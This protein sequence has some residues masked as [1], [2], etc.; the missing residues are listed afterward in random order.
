MQYDFLEQFS[1]RIKNIAKYAVL[2]SN[3]SQKAIWKNYGFAE[4]Y[5]Q[6]TVL[7]AVMLF[8]MEK[9]LRDDDCTMDDIS[10]FLDELNT[11]Y[12]HRDMS[13]EDC[14]ILSDFLINTVLS[15]DGIPM[16]YQAYSFE[17][18]KCE[19]V[20][21]SYL[22]NKIVYDEHNV[23]RTSYK[24]TDMGYDFILGTLEIEDNL[25]LS[26]QE[27]VFKLHLDKQNYDKALDDIKQMFARMRGQVERIQDA[28]YRIR[29]NPLNYNVEEYGNV[30]QG[31]LDT[32][33][34]I[35]HKLQ[36]YREK[37]QEI[38]VEIEGADIV[39]GTSDKYKLGNLREINA[40]LTMSLA[41]Y[42]KIMNNHF[43][44]K[45][46][47]AE[48]L[49]NIASL[50]MVQRYSLR[51][52]IFDPIMQDIRALDKIDYLLRPL[53]N[54]PLPKYFNIE[55]MLA[56]QRRCGR[57]EDDMQSELEDFDQEAWDRKQEQIRQE[58]NN[59]Y[60]ASLACILKA[61]YPTGHIT[62]VELSELLLQGKLSQAQLIPSIGIFKEIMIELIRNGN[63]DIA[64]MR[65]E[66][67]RFIQEERESFSLNNCIL[68]VLDENQQWNNI[69][70]IIVTKILGGKPA[71]FENILTE[72][73]VKRKILCSNV[74]ISVEVGI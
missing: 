39:D 11:Q 55:K 24:L 58:R 66:H 9:S 6:L 27:M 54:K 53:F 56:P 19:R 15:N 61:A 71:V 42:Q 73:G 29:R 1:R 20:H 3:S 8:I 49:E 14:R 41:E 17:A 50:S 36:L 33:S 47:Y 26:V 31:D 16:Y 46:L 35:R 48:A 45:F 59:Q 44:L 32:I 12:F 74:D 34:E 10:S 30:L 65:Q 60:E 13:M 68:K 5:Q 25:K 21:I 7:L 28:M 51:T 22:S 2:L 57:E 72:Q 18:M 64:L 43:D 63:L 40:Y 69:D 70:K 67:Q 23:R 52:E 37:I 4:E 38:I 62:L